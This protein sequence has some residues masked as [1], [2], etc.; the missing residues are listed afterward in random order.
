MI[1]D[2]TGQ[3]PATMRAFAIDRFGE[4]SSQRIPDIVR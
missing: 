2:V 1:H 4:G 3:I